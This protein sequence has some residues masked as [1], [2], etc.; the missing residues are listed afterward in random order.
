MAN[1]FR[2]TGTTNQGLVIT[3]NPPAVVK[4]MGG[5]NISTTKVRVL[6]TIDDVVNKIV[7]AYT[8][9]AKG[10]IL[11]SGAT[12]DSIGQWTDTDVEARVRQ[13]ILSGK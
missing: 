5:I 11:W 7:E 4:T 9:Q 1:T 6:K 3:F 8:D 2:S 12:Y 13:I 10:Y